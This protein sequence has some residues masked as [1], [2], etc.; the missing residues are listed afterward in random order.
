MK[1]KVIAL[2][3]LVIVLSALG[4]ISI[5]RAQQQ[6]IAAEKIAELEEKEKHGRIDFMERVQLAKGK[7]KQRLVVPALV[8]LYMEVAPSPDEL[9]QKLSNYTVVVAQLIEKKSYMPVPDEP[10]IRT[11]NKFKI[12]ETLSQ[13]PPRQTHF[14]WPAIPEE[15]LP[16]KEEEILV[17]TEGGT[18]VADGVEIAQ[19]DA[20]VPAFR[21]S[22]KYLLVL[23]LDPSTRIGWLE[24]GPQSLLPIN[25][26]NTL[27]VAQDQNYL[28]QAIKERHGG[29]VNQL[30]GSLRN[31]S[32]SR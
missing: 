12:I 7:G 31:R 14:S 21:K 25:L 9:N 30:K 17:H 28:Q 3:A 22:Q 15:L 29:S 11:W 16:L 6:N 24:L 18:V 20:D 2:T 32:G 4:I 10:V 8:T 13:V 26:D 27:D 1:T 19:G 23:S 5:S